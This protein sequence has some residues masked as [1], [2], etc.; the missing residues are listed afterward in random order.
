MTREPI[1]ITL[2]LWAMAVPMV[3][4]ALVAMPVVW[5]LI[6]M[7]KLEGKARML[8][9][10]ERMQRVVSRNIGRSTRK[11]IWDHRHRPHDHGG[12]WHEFGGFLHRMELALKGE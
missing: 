5:L 2:L 11:D 8:W 3:L 10:R 9:D 1:A 12:G 6:G 7:L 4:A